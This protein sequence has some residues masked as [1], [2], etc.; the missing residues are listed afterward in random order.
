MVL[1]LLHK[2]SQESL[3]FLVSKGCKHLLPMTVYLLNK[4]EMPKGAQ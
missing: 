3:Y 1:C 4:T 2:K